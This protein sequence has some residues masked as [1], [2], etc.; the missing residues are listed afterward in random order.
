MNSINTLLFEETLSNMLYAEFSYW[1]S[2]KERLSIK[3]PFER[4]EEVITKIK[5]FGVFQ[6]GKGFLEKFIQIL[7]YAGNIIG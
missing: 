5:T 3:Y 1:E 6:D 4:T 2:N 7:T